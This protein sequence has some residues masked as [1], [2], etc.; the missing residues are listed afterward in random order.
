MF[1]YLPFWNNFLGP[2]W[3][4]SCP[5]GASSANCNLDNFHV[6]GNNT[7]WPEIEY[8][9]LYY[10]PPWWLSDK[11]STCNAR[12][13][14]SVPFLGRSP[15]EGNGNPLQYSCRENPMGRGAWKATVHGVTKSWIWLSDNSFFHFSH[16][17]LCFIKNLLLDSSGHG[18][19]SEEE[20]WRSDFWEVRVELFSLLESLY[21]T[22]SMPM[23]S[24]SISEVRKLFSRVQLFSTSRTVKSMEFT[25]PEYWSR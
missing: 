23:S 14:G 6:P 21:V 22:W 4:H 25:R 1:K 15:G 18:N 7:T 17:E 24:C 13:L 3:S 5:R 8:S 20:E 10:G 11:E 19:W 16:P 2:R 12:D 9:I